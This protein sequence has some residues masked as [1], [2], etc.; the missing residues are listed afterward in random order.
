MRS[1]DA[2]IGFPS[3]VFAFTF[4]QELV[5]RT[6]NLELGKYSHF[7]GSLHLYDEYAARARDYLNEGFQT[8]YGMPPMPP[9]DPWNSVNWLLEMEQSI[10]CGSSE[11][12]PTD[13]DAYWLDLGRLLKTKKSFAQRDMRKLV[14]LKNEMANPVYT[15]FI[16]GRQASLARKLE[17]QPQPSLPGIAEAKTG[18]PS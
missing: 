9:G 13:I 2:Y 12:A 18:R 15:E 16:R 8:P 7:V 17:P 5:A 6:L 1:N 10:R 11:P 14:Q 3:D 4:I